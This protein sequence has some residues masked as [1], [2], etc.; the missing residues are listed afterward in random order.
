M[1]AA[2]GA[3]LVGNGHEVLWVVRG[4]QRATRVRARDADGLIDV[5]D[6]RRA[7]DAQ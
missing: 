5:G 4:P 7:R 6:A 1:G 3:A 2:I